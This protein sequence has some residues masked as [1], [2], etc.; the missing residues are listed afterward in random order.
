[1]TQFEIKKQNKNDELAKRLRKS[2]KQERT[3]KEKRAQR[4][5]WCLS[6]VDDPDEETIKEVERLVD[7][8]SL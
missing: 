7:E 2:A 4:V 8:V 5:S 1:M 3:P 6:I